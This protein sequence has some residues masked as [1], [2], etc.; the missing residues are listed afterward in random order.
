MSRVVRLPIA[1]AANARERPLRRFDALL[2]GLRVIELRDELRQ[3][4]G[5]RAWG[6]WSALTHAGRKE[7][8]PPPPGAQKPPPPPPPPRRQP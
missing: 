8:N 7:P 6:D 2:S 5:T 1:N 3:P 4:D